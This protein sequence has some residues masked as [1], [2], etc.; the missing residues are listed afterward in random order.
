M[1]AVTLSSHNIAKKTESKTASMHIITLFTLL[2]L[3]GT[4]MAV[5]A[6][7]SSLGDRRTPSTRAFTGAD[8]NS[9]Q[10][11]FSTPIFEGSGE[12]KGWTTNWEL[13]HMFFKIS[14]PIMALT[15]MIWGLYMYIT[16]RKPR[17]STFS[18]RGLGEDAV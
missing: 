12:S 6:A 2:F 15:V 1:E 18:G 8:I 13:L 3:P 14:F 17:A 4:F 11:F 5:R 10:T 7:L 16:K 9:E